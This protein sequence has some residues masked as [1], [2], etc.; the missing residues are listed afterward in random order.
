[1]CSSTEYGG[2]IVRDRDLLRI[3]GS[4]IKILTPLTAAEKVTLKSPQWGLRS[5]WILVFAV[6]PVVIKDRV[7]GYIKVEP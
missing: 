3:C 7:S 1:M 2:Q 4:F 5:A 6:S